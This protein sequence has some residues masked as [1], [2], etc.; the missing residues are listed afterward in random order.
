MER[1]TLCFRRRLETKVEV[2]AALRLRREL[3]TP[4]RKEANF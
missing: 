2:P 4:L 1:E 3:D